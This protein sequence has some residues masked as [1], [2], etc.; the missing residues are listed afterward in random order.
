MP[1]IGHS[2]VAS[3][4]GR[5]PCVGAPCREGAVDRAVGFG[6]GLGTHSGDRGRDGGGWR[7]RLPGMG[8]GHR[9]SP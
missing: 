1:H 8:A 7:R 6:A 2:S 5:R 3:L 4:C 9:E